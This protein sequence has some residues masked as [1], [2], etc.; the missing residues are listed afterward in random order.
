MNQLLLVVS[1]C[2]LYLLQL[3]ISIYPCHRRVY[4]DL[5]SQVSHTYHS[6]YI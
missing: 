3:A 5:L 2:A 1:L 6:L 4:F